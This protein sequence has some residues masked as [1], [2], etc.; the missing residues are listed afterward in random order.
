MGGGV[1]SI[2]TRTSPHLRQYYELLL[3][4]QVRAI[5]PSPT[6]AILFY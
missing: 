2:V 3:D 5:Q 1:K 6:V 4:M